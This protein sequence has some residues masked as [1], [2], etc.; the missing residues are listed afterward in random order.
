LIFT[1]SD[2]TIGWPG[3]GAQDGVYVWKILV[4]NKKNNV[5]KEEYIGHVVLLR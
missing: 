1:S 5:S 4:G 3:V 2:F